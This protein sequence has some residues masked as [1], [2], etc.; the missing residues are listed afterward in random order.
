MKV[1]GAAICNKAY[2]IKSVFS[3]YEVF[4]FPQEVEPTSIQEV[5]KGEGIGEEELSTQVS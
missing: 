4:Y 1:L 5:C 3:R 2:E